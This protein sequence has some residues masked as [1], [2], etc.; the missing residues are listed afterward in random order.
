[1]PISSF[2]KEN[3]C[4]LIITSLTV[5]IALVVGISIWPKAGAH[6]ANVFFQIISI[7][8]GSVIQLMGLA[9]LCFLPKLGIFLLWQNKAR[10]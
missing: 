10:P 4:P 1:M 3:D 9:A 7:H 2:I 5:V 8:L 6:L